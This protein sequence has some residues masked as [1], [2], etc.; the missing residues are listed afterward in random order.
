MIARIES[1]AIVGI[2]ACGV[3][4]E[5]H[6]AGG[7]PH[8]SIV[9]LPDTAI[10]ESRERVKAGIINSE[11]EFPKRRITV[12]LAPADLKKEGPSFDLPIALSVLLATRQIKIKRKG[13]YVIAG[14]LALDGSVRRVA[15]IL[16]FSL[17]ARAAGKT[18]I[19][20]PADN[21]PEAALV[22]RLQVIP[23]NSLFEAASFLSCE[24]EIKPVQI[25]IAR[26]LSREQPE[27]KDMREI[28]GQEQAK[29]AME[30]AAAGGHNLLMFG[31]P[32]SGKTMLA[33][34]FPG[35]LPSMCIDEAIETTKVYSTARMLTPDCPLITSRPFRSPHHT[36]SDI[37]LIGGGTIPRPG[38]ISLSHNGV[39]FLDEVNEFKRHVLEVMRQPLENGCVTV[40]R[41]AGVVDYPTEF[42]LLAAMNPC[43]CGYLG[44]TIRDCVCTP[45][46]IRGYRA[47]MSG[48]LRD[49]IDIHIQVN[50]IS[51]DS[52]LSEH[53]SE[54]SDSVRARVTKARDIQ[55]QRLAEY[56]M[57]YGIRVNARLRPRMLRKFCALEPAAKDFISD[58]IDRLGLTARSYSKVVKVARTIAD[59]DGSES[60]ALNHIAEAVQYRVLDREVTVN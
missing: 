5:A 50:R 10:R 17:F 53:D 58:A 37:G 55:Q 60:I 31:P 38:E 33:E 13:E 34:A 2:D 49:R 4:V 23:V 28:R 19:I 25:N 8:F 32:G 41:A 56:G 21:A 47:R 45:Q 16:S 3:D 12:N 43:P 59:L 39:L 48:P 35:I 14:E 27:T 1:S 40:S 18:G 29:R 54:P 20:V 44:D 11:Y 26:L 9:G 15:G 36:I 46:E 24:A 30:I 52:M 51:K 7:L 22:E 57:E 6:V 42:A